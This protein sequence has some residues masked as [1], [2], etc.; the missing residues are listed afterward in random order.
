MPDALP[1][2]FQEGPFQGFGTKS[3]LTRPAPLSPP[4]QPSAH[5]T[6]ALVVRAQGGITLGLEQGELDADFCH[7]GIAQ[8]N[9]NQVRNCKGQ[10]QDSFFQS[11]ALLWLPQSL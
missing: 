6:P 5:S 7:L 8:R 11:T 3:W 2:G 1:G 4:A 10:L 9:A